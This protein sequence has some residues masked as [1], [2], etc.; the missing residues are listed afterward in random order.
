M[1]KHV[2]PI[3][4]LII[5]PMRTWSNLIIT[6]VFLMSIHYHKPYHMPLILS[7]HL[8]AFIFSS[9]YI[10]THAVYVNLT[11]F[12]PNSYFKSKIR[13]KRLSKIPSIL[14]SIPF[15]VFLPHN[16]GWCCSNYLRK[17]EYLNEC[18]IPILIQMVTLVQ[19]GYFAWWNHTYIWMHGGRIGI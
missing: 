12:A 3:I 11:K 2:F 16:W 14:L 8:R 19:I 1:T 15:S 13:R 7:R 17:G 9:L 5:K 10:W 4:M 6:Q 18:Y